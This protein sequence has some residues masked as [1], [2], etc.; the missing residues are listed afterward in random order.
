MSE[1]RGGTLERCVRV[2]ASRVHEKCQ[3]NVFGGTLSCSFASR[4]L[5]VMSNIL[6]FVLRVLVMVRRGF[7][8]LRYLPGLMIV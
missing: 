1:W 8:F 5:Y 7:S 3:D 2:A 4:K 6:V